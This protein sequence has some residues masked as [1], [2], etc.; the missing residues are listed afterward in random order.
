MNKDHHPIE[1]LRDDIQKSQRNTLWPDVL[2]NSIRVDE[3]F[4]KGSPRITPL[5]RMGIGLVALVFLSLGFLFLSESYNEQSWLT[6]L[7]SLVV[8]GIG[9]LFLRNA[10]RKKG[11]AQG[12]QSKRN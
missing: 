10:I 4:W 2:H 5:Q 6:G 11:P 12:H 9:G 3:L 8:F 1:E 7:F